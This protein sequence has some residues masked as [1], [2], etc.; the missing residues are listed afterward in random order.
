MGYDATTKPYEGEVCLRGPAVFSGYHKRPE[1]TQKDYCA[2]HDDSLQTIAQTFPCMR[3]EMFARVSMQA[4]T[5][6][7]SDSR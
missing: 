1:L 2:F 5:F 7:D 3:G 6:F 4:R